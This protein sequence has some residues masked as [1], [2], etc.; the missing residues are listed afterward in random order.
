MRVNDRILML[1][2]PKTGGTFLSTV[3]D[4]MGLGLQ[5][6]AE[7]GLDKHI[8]LPDVPDDL[9]KDRLI[10]APIRSP[11]SWYVS[12]FL[13]GSHSGPAAALLEPVAD[14]PAAPT[15]LGTLPRMLAPGAMGV[16]TDAEIPYYP[17]FKP[18]A[19]CA[20]ENRGL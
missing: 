14:D 20:I 18:Y 5:T 15:F 4:E 13:H 12:W 16:D 7:V 1:H 11:M 9:V 10:L 2:V 8:A 3:L 19:T 6:E 17:G